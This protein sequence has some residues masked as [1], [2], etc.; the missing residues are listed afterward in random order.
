MYR[1]VRAVRRFAEFKV[2]GKESD[3]VTTALTSNQADPYNNTA[4]LAPTTLIRRLGQT[5]SDMLAYR[6]RFE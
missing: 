4:T 3:R 2:R 1:E 5:A 6:K